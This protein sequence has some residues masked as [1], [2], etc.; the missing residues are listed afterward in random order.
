M[1]IAKTLRESC[2]CEGR[3]CELCRAADEIERL[4]AELEEAKKFKD[5]MLDVLGGA[6]PN[7]HRSTPFE[8]FKG[9]TPCLRDEL[10]ALQQM[11]T[12]QGLTIKRQQDEL[13]ECRAAASD[14]AHM[15]EIARV[16]GGLDW[17]WTNLHHSIAKRAWEKLTAALAAKGE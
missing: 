13:A 2:F 16:W 1:D 17:S 5:G 4:Q 15:L 6:C 12:A 9:C 3:G 7:D 11:Y 8:E 10:A 14:A